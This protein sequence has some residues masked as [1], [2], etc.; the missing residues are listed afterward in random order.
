P[1]STSDLCRTPSLATDLHW[2]SLLVLAVA[3]VAPP[4]AAIRLGGAAEGPSLVSW[5]E[6]KAR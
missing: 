1:R 5:A 3:T 2:T 6:R 4:K